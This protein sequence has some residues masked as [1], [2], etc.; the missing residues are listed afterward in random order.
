MKFAKFLM[1]F[2]LLLSGC[3]IMKEEKSIVHE[4]SV[5]IVE[6]DLLWVKLYAKENMDTGDILDKL[7][8]DL[9]SGSDVVSALNKYGKTFVDT[10]LNILT[11][12]KDNFVF[13]VGN[14]VAYVSALKD[15]KMIVGYYSTGIKGDV[16]LTNLDVDKYI[17]DYKL[18]SSN[19]IKMVENEKNKILSMPLMKVKTFYQSTIVEAKYP[20]AVAIN[21]TDSNQ[22]EIIIMHIK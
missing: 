20:K 1:I 14:T 6:V 4:K 7:N 10:K 12:N 3:S 18:E 16:K 15:N 21:N 19:L 5:E 11:K 2:S 8:I 22:Y 9:H 17:V 13:E